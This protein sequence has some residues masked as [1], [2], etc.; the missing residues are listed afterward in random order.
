MKKVLAFAAA[1]CVTVLFLVGLHLPLMGFLLLGIAQNIDLLLV[2]GLSVIIVLAILSPMLLLTEP[3][4][5]YLILG[6]FF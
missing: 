2:L 1:A 4:G 6:L 5:L 3:T